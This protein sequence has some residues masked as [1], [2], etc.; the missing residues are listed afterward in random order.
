METV[1]VSRTFPV[2]PAAVRETILED[3]PA[4]VRASGFDRVAVDDEQITLARDVGLASFELTLETR[5]TEHVLAFEQVEGI[6]DTMWT[7]Y[8]VQAAGEGA[9]LTATT[10]FTLGTVLGPVLDGTMIRKRRTEEFEA[11]MEYLEDQFQSEAV[12]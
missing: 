9:T 2:S 4:F 10:D 5:E 7:E 12:E 11:Q 1:T 8:Q 6:F 3:V